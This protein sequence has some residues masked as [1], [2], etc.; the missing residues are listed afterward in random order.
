MVS[1]ATILLNQPM[2]RNLYSANCIN[3]LYDS[4][5]NVVKA[6]HAH[7]SS[8]AA[9]STKS[10]IQCGL[11]QADVYFN[12]GVIHF[13]SGANTGAVRTVK[14]YDVGVLTLAYP[15]PHPPETGDA[16]TVYP[17]CNKTRADC[18]TKFSNADNFRGFPYIPVPEASV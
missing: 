16:F 7:N 10:V 17:G 14:E 11:S 15:L 5:C 13:T 6:S 3:T 1:A 8:V 2:P 18:L 9:G 4:A 12:N